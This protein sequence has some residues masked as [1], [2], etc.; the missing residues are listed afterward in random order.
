MEI[1]DGSSIDRNKLYKITDKPKDILA[2]TNE[3]Q[4]VSYIL[5]NMVGVFDEWFSEFFDKDF[6]KVKR[7]QSQANYADFKGFMK[8]IYLKEKPMIIINPEIELVDE[9]FY[10]ESISTMYNRIN[11]DDLVG[12]K[13]LYSTDLISTENVCVYYRRNRYRIRFDIMMVERS[14]S[15]QTDLFNNIVMNIRHR[16]KFPI[17]KNVLNLIPLNFII[18]VATNNGFDYRSQEFMTFINSVSY[19]PIIKRLIPNGQYMFYM[20]QKVNIDVNIPDMPSK[21][22]V[23]NIGAIEK[24]ARVVD[25]VEFEVNVPAEYILTIPQSK[26]INDF[27]KYDNTEDVYYVPPIK[28]HPDYK[29]LYEG[30]MLSNIIDIVLKNNS[31]NY[32]TKDTIL[33]NITTK[34]MEDI[35]S[36]ISNSLPIDDVMKLAVY[37][38]GTFT[39]V[40][41]VDKDN[42]ISLVEPDFSKAYSICVYINHGLLNSIREIPFKKDIGTIKDY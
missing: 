11:A 37:E 4:K 41:I 24:G 18:Y 26:L 8:E 5:A 36:Y 42:T 22:G 12:A 29:Q 14:M 32:L 27:A 16:S 17:E 40:D 2:Y 19:A 3:I 33:D 20:A 35:K 21:D 10:N 7:I 6:F 25:R 1:I 13:L 15:R 28:A 34:Y 30:F 9:S 23:D 39:M 38:S 31:E